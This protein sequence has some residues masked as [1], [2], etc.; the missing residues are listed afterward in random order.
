MTRCCFALFTS[1]S[2][3]CTKSKYNHIHAA[4]RTVWRRY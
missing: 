4:H 1:A 2:A 3:Y